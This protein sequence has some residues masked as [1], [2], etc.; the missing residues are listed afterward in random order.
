MADP[1]IVLQFFRLLIG[2]HDFEEAVLSGII[3]MLISPFI[4]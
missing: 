1:S 2:N 4:S 3:G